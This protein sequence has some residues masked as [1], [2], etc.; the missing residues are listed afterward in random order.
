MKN[1]VDGEEKTDN[2]GVPYTLE[3][4][5][6]S[7]YVICGWECPCIFFFVFTCFVF[8]PSPR[9]FSISVYFLLPIL[10]YSSIGRL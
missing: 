4:L 7:G 1:R 5:T 8:P 3:G 2:E 9:A 10:S 6:K